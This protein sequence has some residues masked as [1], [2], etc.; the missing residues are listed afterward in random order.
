MRASFTACDFYAVGICSDYDCDVT[1][2]HV[3]TYCDDTVNGTR[4][5]PTPVSSIPSQSHSDSKCPWQLRQL[6]LIAHWYDMSFYK[7]FSAVFACTYMSS[8]WT[9]WLAQLGAFITVTIGTARRSI[10]GCCWVMHPQNNCKRE[11][12]R[13]NIAA[14]II[15]WH[16][17]IRTQVPTGAISFGYPFNICHVSVIYS[18]HG[19]HPAILRVL[20]A[21][22]AAHEFC[23]LCRLL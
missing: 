12:T 13:N 1:V 15:Y 19:T 20:P 17:I 14:R 22:S 23:V 21:Y 18:S 7:I 3:I 2:R 8:S 4:M 9:F 10:Y 5:A 11:A 6:L 16:R